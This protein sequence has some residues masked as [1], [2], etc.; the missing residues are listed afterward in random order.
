MPSI[1]HLTLGDLAHELAGTRRVL[2]RVPLD[3]ADWKP[4]PKSM[5]LGH[6]A[7]H[8]AFAPFYGTHML[9]HPRFDMAAPM[10]PAPPMA[11]TTAELLAA[12]DRTSGELMAALDAADDA[13]LGSSWE[14]TH[15]DTVLQS[16]PLS[17]ALRS[18]VPNH[19]I[20]HRA[21]LTVY[22]RLLDVP[23]PGLYGPSADEQ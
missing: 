11:T 20:H 9:A 17:A 21:Q 5:S 23:V 18:W 3:K 19:L 2:E 1:R 22:L 14:M 6:L 4:H 8:I 13:K 16:M 12:F 10:P 7:M 15:G